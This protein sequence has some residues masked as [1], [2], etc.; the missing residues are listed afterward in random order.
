MCRLGTGRLGALAEGRVAEG[1][2]VVHGETDDSRLIEE[3]EA[4]GGI[5]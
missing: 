3:R 4:G 1:L 5:R 2:R